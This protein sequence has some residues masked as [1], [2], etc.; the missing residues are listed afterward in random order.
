MKKFILLTAALF[1]G[2]YSLFSAP[3]GIGSETPD[4]AK[5]GEAAP[6]NNDRQVRALEFYIAALMEQNPGKRVSL[7]LESVKLDPQKR[8]PLLILVKTVDKV[9]AAVP[10]VKKTMDQLRK[11]YPLDIFLAIHSVGISQRAGES[12]ESIIKSIRPVL[13]QK[14]DKKNAK[15]FNALAQAYVHLRLKTSVA[16]EILPFVPDDAVL[17]ETALLYYA[18]A[19][20]RDALLMRKS[21]AEN[22]R[23]KYLAELAGAEF[24]ND[25][26]L[27]R[28]LALLNALKE[29]E[30]AFA[31]AGKAVLKKK[32]LMTTL[33]FLEAAARS[34]KLDVLKQELKKY[35]SLPVSLCALLRFQCYQAQ[36]NFAEA[37]EELVNFSE[38]DG[39]TEKLLQI[40]RQMND[41]PGMKKILQTLEKA[42]QK[43]R[44]FLALGYLNLAEA[45]ADVSAFEKAKT[46]LGTDYLQNP[47]LANAVGYVSA[48]VGKDLQTAEMLLEFALAKEP[49]NAAYLD[50]MAWVKYKRRDYKQALEYIRLAMGFLDNSVGISVISEHAGDI[51]Q[52]SGDKVTAQK[53]YKMALE[54]YNKDKVGNADFNPETLRKKLTD[55]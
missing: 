54:A 48:V 47:V 13:L 33:F 5:C 19:A 45:A 53:Y 44:A 24:S 55:K 38:K 15:D 16:T 25:A 31:A 36:G 42:P 8:L 41:I 50:S 17:K 51:Y 6:V 35:S 30:A 11:T 4:P 40:S 34:G 46:L 1:A 2:A 28:H 22:L 29:F 10:V 20:R 12:P 21:S 39:K 37:R 26:D 3:N 7:L 14:K 43:N 32:N 49:R 23:Q 18:T 27:R 52:A 9:P